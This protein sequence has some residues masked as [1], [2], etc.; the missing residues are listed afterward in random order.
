MKEE[1]PEL[2]RQMEFIIKQLNSG[3]SKSL[4]GYSKILLTRIVRHRFGH[5]DYILSLIF[6]YWV[7]N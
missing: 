7:V 2:N 5:V 4:Q 3:T 1:N 6:S